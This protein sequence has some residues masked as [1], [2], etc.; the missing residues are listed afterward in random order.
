MCTRRHTE[1]KKPHS[2]YPAAPCSAPMQKVRG[3]LEKQS[4]GVLRSGHFPAE[5]TDQAP[6]CRHH[7]GQLSARRLACSPR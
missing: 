1:P 7:F 5:A 6:K 4:I 2:R 3:S